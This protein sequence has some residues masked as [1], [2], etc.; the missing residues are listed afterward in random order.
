[1]SSNFSII[2]K[3]RNRPRIDEVLFLK[4]K[5][6]I[7]GKRYELSVVFVGED[8]IKSLNK[9]YRSKDR[10]TDILSFPI[11]KDA[12]E[13]FICDKKSKQKSKLYKRSHQNFLYFLFIH[14]LVHLKGF[15]HGDIMEKVEE[16]FR[17]KFHI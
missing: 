3:T 16:K 4:I 10:A 11:T 14:G 1:M 17:K 9:I 15:D 13:V 2:Y 12:G 6:A 7:L 8:K 5:D